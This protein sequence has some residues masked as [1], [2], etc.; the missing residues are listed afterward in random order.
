MSFHKTIKCTDIEDFILKIKDDINNGWIFRGQKKNSWVLNPSIQRA[1]IRFDVPANHRLRVERNMVR[2]FKRRLHHYSDN[3]PMAKATDEW[4]ALMQHHG[5]PTRL[6]DFSYS[7]YVAAY[8]AFEH[9]E[10]KNTVAIWA[11]EDSWFAHELERISQEKY[12]AFESY[13]KSREE[14]GNFDEIFINRPI[15]LILPVNPFRLNERLA[16]QR[17]VFLCPGDI[18]EPFEENYKIYGEEREVSKHL[19][20]YI[21]KTGTNNENTTGALEY[22]DSMNV[23]RISLFPGLD[24]FGQSFENRISSLFLK[25]F[26]G[27]DEKWLKKGEKLP[28]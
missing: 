18:S 13:R 9:S 21:I 28:D 11:V 5:V 17:G 6:I 14:S 1:F 22:L 20:K 12:Q 15:K 19:I 23:S 27:P 4:L 7:P 8:F 25:Q 2:E 16:Y 3:I 26:V 24:G 10:A